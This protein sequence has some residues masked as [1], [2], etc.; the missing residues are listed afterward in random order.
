MPRQGRDTTNH[1]N[2]ARL[3]LNSIFLLKEFLN[4]INEQ[5]SGLVF[6][7]FFSF[8]A[9]ISD[10]KSKSNSKILVLGTRNTVRQANYFLLTLKI[11]WVIV[12]FSTKI[13]FEATR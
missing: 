1:E 4:K 13:G 8:P 7:P 6:L 11:H 10:I 2:R 9:A 3:T 12:C 5:I